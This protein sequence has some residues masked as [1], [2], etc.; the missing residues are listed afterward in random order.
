MKTKLALAAAAILAAGA[1]VAQQQRK[2]TDLEGK[3]VP[4][5]S[6][7]NALGKEFTAKN[8]KGQVVFIDFW[9][10]WCGPCKAAGPTVQALHEKY[11]KK[12][13]LVI[14]ANAFERENKDTAAATYAKEHSYTYLMTSNNDALARSWGVAGIPT[15]VIIGKDGIVKKVQVGFGGDATAKVLEDAVVSALNEK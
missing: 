15:F 5:F 7:K 2:V 1:I 13:L 8:L 4:E 11:G 14:G 9:A 3:P 6:M 12:G 10:S